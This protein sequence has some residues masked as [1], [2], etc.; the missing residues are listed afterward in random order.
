MKLLPENQFRHSLEIVR[1]L[2]ERY[3]ITVTSYKEAT[4]G[5]ENTTL[6]VTTATG[7]YVFRI[8]RQAKKIDARFKPKSTLCLI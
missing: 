2:G 8:Y 4:S 6:I 5:I 3:G 7:K 1:L